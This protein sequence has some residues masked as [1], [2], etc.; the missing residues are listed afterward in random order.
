MTKQLQKAFK[1][2]SALPPQEQDVI[3]DWLLKELESEERW[4]RL[5]ANSQGALS[6]LAAE[7]LEEHHKGETR[8]LEAGRQ[9]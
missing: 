8:N 1:K 5:F 4:G 7:A 6:K 2:A 9:E 3:A